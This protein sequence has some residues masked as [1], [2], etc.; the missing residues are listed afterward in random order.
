M[1][2]LIPLIVLMGGLGCNDEELLPQDYACQMPVEN[3]GALP[4]DEILGVMDQY[5]DVGFPGISLS[6]SRNNEKWSSAAGL[7]DLYN[8]V[9]LQGCEPMLI[10]SIS[11]VF[12]ATLIFQLQEEEQISIEDRLSDHLQGEFMDKIENAK[13]VTIQ[14]LLNHT[15]GLYDYLDPLKFELLSINEPFKKGTPKEKLKL[16][17]GK[18]PTNKPGEKYA[19]SNTNYVLLGL[20]IEN[21][22]SKPLEEVL[23][24]RIFQPLNLTSAYMGTSK[25]PIPDGT[26]KGYLSIHA[27]NDLQESTFWYHYDLATGDG[28]IAMN[29]SDL[30]TFMVSLNQGMLIDP[31]SLNEMK[32]SFELP[33]GWKGFFH[34]FNSQGFEIYDTPYGLAF[35][36]TGGIVGFT[37]VSWYFPNDSLALSYS[38]NGISPRINNRLEDFASDLMDVLFVP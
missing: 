18:K 33:E 24:D 13:K 38:I 19:Y 25:K 16:A 1:K 30:N 28:G 23:R 14:Q 21:K 11:K 36:H 26:P 9:P 17:Y 20:L 4:I 7:G 6:V 22:L 31:T 5:V 10:A 12:V 2:K 29:M 27:N 3:A 35:G 32:E 34:E 15:S 37:S 8:E